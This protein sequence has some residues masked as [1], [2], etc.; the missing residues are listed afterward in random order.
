MSMH[1]RD[2]AAHAAPDGAISPEEILT[3]RR[4]SWSDGRIDAEEAEAI[5]AINKRIRDHDADWADFFVESV[6]EFVLKGAEPLGHVDEAKADWLISWIARDGMLETLAELELVVRL[7]ERASGAPQRLKDFAIAQIEQAVLTSAGPTRRG[8]AL[9]PG[10]I[11][12]GEAQLL[13]RL[14]FAPASDRPAGVSRAEAELLFRLKDASIGA[15]HGD[16][17]KRLFVQGVGNY[18]S[19]YTSYEPLSRERAAELEE[20]MN[21]P[22]AGVG[23]FFAQVARLDL[24]SGFTGLLG[25]GLARDRAAEEAEALAIPADEPR[26]LN[27]QVHADAQVDEYERA[28]MDFLAE[29]GA[30][31]KVR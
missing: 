15:A 31:G 20:F 3:L 21:R 25:R 30:R 14:L 6:T 8:G 13:R 5:F 18:L 23:R 29:E 28:L 19:A 4:A 12:D 22:S 17:W 24:Q 27:A 26:C 16:E 2:L 1:F 9:D 7:L 11:T 10:A